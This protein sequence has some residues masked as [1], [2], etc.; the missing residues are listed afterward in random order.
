MFR[1]RRFS[2]I[3]VHRRIAL[4][5]VALVLQLIQDRIGHRRQTGAERAQTGNFLGVRRRAVAV[6]ALVRRRRGFGFLVSALA[7]VVR[8]PRLCLVGGMVFRGGRR[9]VLVALPVKE[10]QE[11]RQRRFEIGGVQTAQ[12]S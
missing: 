10:T 9:V 5:R 12:E 4:L 3:P 1:F 11:V 6:H 7:V 2:N 8:G